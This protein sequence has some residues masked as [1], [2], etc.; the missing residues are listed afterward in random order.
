V[1][2]ARLG[3]L[4]QGVLCLA[5]LAGAV[6]AIRARDI[7]RHARFMLQ[8]GAIVFGAVVLRL[9]MALAAVLELPFDAAYAA[10]AWLCWA[11]PLAIVSIRSPIG[12]RQRLA[13]AAG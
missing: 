7:E 4:T 9:M 13:R 10:T 3:F 1:P 12:H 2:L 8:V 11:L 5:F 6:W